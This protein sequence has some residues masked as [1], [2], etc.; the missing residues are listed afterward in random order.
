MIK[1]S[2]KTATLFLAATMLTSSCVGSFSLFNKLAS[3]NRKATKYKLINELIFLVISPAYAFCGAADLFVL[4]TI[5]FWSGDNPIAQNTGKTINVKGS[6]GLMY[7][8]KYLS[9]GYQVTKADG[10]VYCFI[11]NAENDSWSMQQNGE[12]KEILRFNHDGTIKTTLPGGKKIDVALNRGGLFELRMAMAG[13][14]YMM[15]AR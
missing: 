9:N 15:A 1:K 6:D 3:W 8:V 4:N 12:T 14:T 2:L 13:D 5:E 7:A 10:Q 11:H